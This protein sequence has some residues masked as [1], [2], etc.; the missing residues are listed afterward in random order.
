MT[1]R[2]IVMLAMLVLSPAISGGLQAGN[3]TAVV[4]SESSGGATSREQTA[5]PDPRAVTWEYK[6]LTG[7]VS[8]L[9]RYTVTD[10]RSRSFGPNLEEEINRFA[11]QGYVVDG[12]QAFPSVGGGA[13]GNLSTGSPEVV[14][15]LKRMRK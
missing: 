5:S 11:A 7:S 1:K 9:V 2:S 13:S 15:I 8:G 3:F 4:A 10:A 12:F 14:V 6:I